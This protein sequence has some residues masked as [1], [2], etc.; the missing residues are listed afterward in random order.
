MTPRELSQHRAADAELALKIMEL[1]S[2][3]NLLLKE[4][5]HIESELTKLATRHGDVLRKLA[6]HWAETPA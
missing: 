3:R 5:D 4:Q 2:R 6:H 1:K